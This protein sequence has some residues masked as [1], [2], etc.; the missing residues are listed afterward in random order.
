MVQA[1]TTRA[2][3]LELDKRTEATDFL[4][5]QIEQKLDR[6]VAHL[7]PAGARILVL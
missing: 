6:L 1:T 5:R 4:V 3:V 7:L 2:K